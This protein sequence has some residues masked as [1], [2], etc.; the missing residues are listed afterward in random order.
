MTEKD[1]KFSFWFEGIPTGDD[2]RAMTK[3]EAERWY[4]QKIEEGGGKDVHLLEQLLI[5]YI[6]AKETEK[7]TSCVQRLF[8]IL[9][10]D[11]ERSYLLLRLGQISESAGEFN[12][13]ERFYRDSHSMNP[14]NSD[15]QYWVNNNLGYCLNVLGMRCC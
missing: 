5:L 6:H 8:E 14:P 11:A 2:L 13:A 9:E 12:A 4:L 3:E 7:A 10:G 15:T 1:D